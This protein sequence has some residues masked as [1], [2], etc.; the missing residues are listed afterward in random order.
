MQSSSRRLRDRA[1]AN[2]LKR[3]WIQKMSVLFLLKVMVAM[4]SN[5][6]KFEVCSVHFSFEREF[7]VSCS[8]PLFRQR[9]MSLMHPLSTHCF[10]YPHH[11]QNI[12]I[13]APLLLHVLIV[14]LVNRAPV[15]T[16]P[17][18]ILFLC[19]L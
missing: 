14:F 4:A 17:H 13:H 9:T 11:S 10:A 19:L 8:H 12:S 7:D 15:L 16:L 5:H 2:R 6:K 18:I 3:K 1:A